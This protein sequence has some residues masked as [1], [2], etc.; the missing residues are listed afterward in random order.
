MPRSPLALAALASVAVPGLDVYD[1]LRS[2]HTDADFDV[3]VVKDAT[4]TRWVVRAPKRPAAGAALE[5]ERSLLSAL[6]RAHDTGLVPFDVP[7][8][9][10]AA[11]LA[12]AEG[13]RAVV[14]SEI[15]GSP[16]VLSRVDPGPGLAAA[17]GTALAAIH[18]LPPTLIEDEG[19][20]TYTAEEYRERRMAELD[21]A[22]DTGKI[23]PRLA[24]RWEHQLENVAWWRFEPTVVHG[25]LGEHQ[26]HVRGDAVVGIGD[27]MDARVADPADDLAWLAA[28][29][30]E[31]VLESI[32][33]AYRMGRREARDPHLIDRARLASEL[34]LVRW[35]MYGVR[36]DNEDVISDGEGMLADL[37]TLLFDDTLD[38]AEA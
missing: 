17:I 37:E 35:L 19:L 23:P 30:P 10:G 16:L 1:V 15:A 2:P 20:P 12:D 27:W 33:E 18:E 36:T 7:R 8:P 22:I 31:D 24:D 4:G 3:V 6:A 5:A 29:A 38:D 9:R 28:S 32:T 26:I 25:D 34:A 13:G 11:T 21:A 14:Y